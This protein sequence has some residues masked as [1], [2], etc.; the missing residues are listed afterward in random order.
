M[1]I[2]LVAVAMLATTSASAASKKANKE[3]APAV[4]P[5]TAVAKNHGGKVWVV[6]DSIPGVEGDGLEK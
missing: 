2:W 5:N 3:A 6:S 1:K 4:D